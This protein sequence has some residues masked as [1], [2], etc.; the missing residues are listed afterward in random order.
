[1][2]T[3]V[4]AVPYVQNGKINSKTN[5]TSIIIST[6][7]GWGLALLFGGTYGIVFRFR[8]KDTA[9]TTVT[10]YGSIPQTTSWTMSENTLTITVL[11]SE[12]NIVIGS[13]EVVGITMQ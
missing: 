3:S 9:P 2:A 13:S 8:G 5:C 1:M 11:M 7:S 6:R 12:H 10:L 4:I